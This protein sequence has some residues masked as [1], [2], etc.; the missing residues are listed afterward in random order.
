MLH[1][2]LVPVDLR[3]ESHRVIE[4]VARLPLAPDA[5]VELL[6]VVPGPLPTA[7]RRGVTHDAKQGLAALATG[8]HE[9]L[10]AQRAA[11][12]TVRTVV[13]VGASADQIAR[14][15]TDARVDL[16]VL[17][18]SGR[19]PLRE[20]L[21]GTTAERVLRQSRRPVLVVQAPVHGAYRRPAAAIDIDDAALPAL[22]LCAGVAPVRGAVPVIHVYDAPFE[23]LMYPSVAQEDR[24]AYR[25]RFREQAARR[26]DGVLR[27]ARFTSADGTTPTRWRPRLRVGSPR[28]EIPSLVA[29]LD[30]DILVLGTHGRAGLAHAFIGTVAGDVLRDVACDV[31]M[32]PPSREGRRGG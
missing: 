29:R 31:L 14:R 10:A 15:A 13:A 8:L 28:M 5:E 12:G 23:G 9:R 24:V 26:L 25:R 1:R 30:V 19:H 32:V 18:R 27:R 7:A 22:R 3:G 11:T 6:H 17:G 21:V 2:I 16:V 20:H 4:R